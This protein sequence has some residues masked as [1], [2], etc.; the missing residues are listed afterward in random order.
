MGLGGG[1]MVHEMCVFFSCDWFCVSVGN[2]RAA[3]YPGL[4]C[5]RGVWMDGW[6]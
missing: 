6:I 2:A 4:W 5:F 1:W 3:R